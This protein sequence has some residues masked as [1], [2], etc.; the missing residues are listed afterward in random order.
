MYT[1]LV[2]VALAIALWTWAY[3]GHLKTSKVSLFSLFML[4][5]LISLELMVAIDHL[6]WARPPS[7]GG[8]VKLTINNAPN[9]SLFVPL[10]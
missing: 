7:D 5:V 2:E 4:M 10:V 6:R 3:W 1:I 9:F 8:E